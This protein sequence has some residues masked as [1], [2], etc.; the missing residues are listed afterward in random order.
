MFVN[1]NHLLLSVILAFLPTGVATYVACTRVRDYWHH[2]S[3]IL[4]GALIGIGCSFLTF[5]IYFARF[6]GP[7]TANIDK[8][9]RLVSN[10]PRNNN[11]NN[12]DGS[13]D[14]KYLER[15]LDSVGS[16]SIS[17]ID[18]SPMQ[19]GSARAPNEPSSMI[20]I[21]TSGNKSGLGKRNH[22]ASKKMTIK[23]D[24]N[25]TVTKPLA[26]SAS[27]METALMQHIDDS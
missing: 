6:Y 5:L 24:N 3:D 19:F 23:Q 7:F 1:R 2:Y 14:A 4:G 22:A 8:F 27:D 13:D 18:G 25:E 11:N 10:V 17:A 15:R 16:M 9:N 26:K 20:K 12:I 21:V